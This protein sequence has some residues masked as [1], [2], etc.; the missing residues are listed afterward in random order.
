MRLHG[1]LTGLACGAGAVVAHSLAGGQV[2]LLTAALAVVVPVVLARLL[3]RRRLTWY[4][5]GLV[6]V[7]SQATLHLVF[8]TS[9]ASEVGCLLSP[10]QMATAHL[11][12]AGFSVLCAIGGE[13]AILRVIS[14]ATASL[15][16][17]LAQLPR[18]PAIPPV[19]ATATVPHYDAQWHAWV[20]PARGPPAN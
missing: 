9:C 1:L 10:A 12:A 11:L 5:A 18:I 14:M 13:R 2:D 17:P 4:G 3:L 8:I 20:A 6:A 15:G 7:A 19:L 16:I